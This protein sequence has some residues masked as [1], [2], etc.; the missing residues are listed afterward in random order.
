MELTL[1]RALQAVGRALEYTYD[2]ETKRFDVANDG[3]LDGLWLVGLDSESADYRKYS[4]EAL[5]ILIDG[6]QAKILYGPFPFSSHPGQV[7]TNATGTPDVDKDGK[8]DVAWAAEGVAYPM[9]GKRNSGN[10]FDPT[11]KYQPVYRDTSGAGNY[12]GVVANSPKMW[13]GTAIQFHAGTSSKP[14]SVGCLTAPPKYFDECAK[15]IEAL[16]VSS[17]RLVFEH[18]ETYA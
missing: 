5:L 15:R 11:T 1:E 3:R 6:E 7:R 14:V 2:A 9:K 17:W 18:R 16:K 10:R 8:R 13:P 4:G 12:V